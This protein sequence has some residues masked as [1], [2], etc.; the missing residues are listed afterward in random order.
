MMEED[1][2]EDKKR[3]LLK[4]FMNFLVHISK[5]SLLRSPTLDHIKF[6]RLERI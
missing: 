6:N 2:Q 3:L 4:T 5:L 1:R